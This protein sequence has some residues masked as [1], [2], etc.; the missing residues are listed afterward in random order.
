MGKN[1]YV[2]YMCA[3]IR[4]TIHDCGDRQCKCLIRWSDVFVLKGDQLLA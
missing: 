3:D 4:L 2:V 1:L